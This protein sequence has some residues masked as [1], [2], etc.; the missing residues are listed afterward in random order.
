MSLLPTS[1]LSDRRLL[2]LLVCIGVLLGLPAG[3]AQGKPL[4]ER[5]SFTPRSDGL[6]YVI[7]IHTS[8]HLPAYSEPRRLEDGQV[9]MILFNAELARAY[10]HA[11][12]EG[13]VQAYTEEMRG[14]HLVLHF[15]LDPRKPVEVAAYR[16]RSSTDLLVGLT[17]AEAA[18]AMLPTPAPPVVTAGHTEAQGPRTTEGERWR[19]DTVVIDAGH[20]G[21]DPGSTANG[22]R[23]KDVVLAVARKLGAAIERELGVEVVYTR[24][25]DRFIELKDRGRIANAAGGK[26][27]ISI[28]AN[29]ARDSRAHGTETFFLGLH[30]TDAARH[31]MERENSVVRLESNPGQYAEMDEQAL[32]RQTLTQS[33]YLRKSEQL[34]GTIEQ[35]FDTGVDRKSRGVKQAGFYVLWGASMPAVLVELGFVSNP[36]EA[37]FL[38]SDH[39]QTS[40]ANA[41]FR[42]VKAYKEQYEKGLSL[43]SSH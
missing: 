40:M 42:A 23:E 21:K 26:L 9:E 33:A 15:R 1:C 6:G 11:D 13:P 5:V 35:Q 41:I 24:D 29:A 36:N 22:V 43:V 34:A 14:G 2:S 17:Y 20:G 4:V 25:D 37:A 32:I 18:A 39:G 19:L 8:A 12:P 16:D 7:R 28:H 30:K 3:A 10:A 27:F 31:V 38:K